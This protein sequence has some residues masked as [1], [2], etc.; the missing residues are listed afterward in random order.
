M[1]PP[2]CS[3][4]PV[5]SRDIPS[6]EWLCRCCNGLEP[7]EDTP[8]LFRPLMEQAC[9]ANPLIFSVPEE[10]KTHELLPGQS[11][12]YLNRNKTEEKEANARKFCFACNQ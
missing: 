4:P 12:R 9:M 6:G 10:L 5:D 1:F 8:P 2:L 3:D 11:K 7:S